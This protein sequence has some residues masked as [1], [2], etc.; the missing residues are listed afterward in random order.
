MNSKYLFLIVFT[1]HFSI[2]LSQQSLI[3]GVV[4][5]ELNKPIPFANVLNLDNSE[6]TSCDENGKFE[7]SIGI[8]QKANIKI[9][10]IG[11]VTS[12]LNL[13]NIVLNKRMNFFLKVDNSIL[14]EQVISS[15]LELIKKKESP[16]QI[17][18]Y[19]T[20]FLNS[21]TSPSLVEATNQISG[22]RPQ[23]N[24]S[25]CNTGDIHINGMEG[26]YSM[27]VID[28]MP[29]MGGLS[30]VYGL[31]GIPT[32]LI[33]QLEVIK[34]PASTLY[35]S[36]AMAGLI[37]VVTKSI[38]CLPKISYDFNISNWGEIQ[39]SI[40]F[41][42]I[43]NDR[44]KAFTT[45]DAFNYN[46]PIDNNEDNFTDLSIKNRVSVFNKFQFL[47]KN[48][49]AHPFNLSFR[50]LNED[51]WGGEMNWD[52]DF[53]GSDSI[54][55]E[56]IVTERFEVYS[57]YQLPIK[58][59]VNW[60]TSFSLHNQK[61]WYGDV[62]YNAKQFIGFNQLTWHKEIKQKHQLL[63]GFAIRYNYYDDNTEATQLSVNNNIVNNQP[64]EWFLPGIF[65]QDNFAINSKHRLLIGWR[66]D[67]HTNHGFIN[68]PRLNYQF[69]FSE[70]S[71]FRIG[72]GN[73][74]RVVNV[75]TEDHAALTG[76]R[77]VVFLEELK[78]EL[79]NNININWTN[80]W[81]ND[82]VKITLESS[83]FQ[84]RFSN[85]IIPDFLTDDNKIIYKNLDGYA[86]SKGISSEVL[87][88]IKSLPISIN[89][90]ATFLDIANYTL[91][92]QDIWIKSNQLL[93]EKYSIK[94]GVNYLL[95]SI[96]IDINYS[97]THYGPIRL[98]ILENDFRPEYSNPYSIHNFKITKK[99]NNGCKLFTGLRNAF[100]FTPPSNSIMRPFDPFDQQTDIN[101][102]NNYTFDASYM[103]A[104]FQGINIIFGGSI[105][106]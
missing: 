103:Y 33:Q 84:S 5:D 28:G 13:Q 68:S 82:M 83:V 18:V 78:P 71:T 77:E 49:N 46:K 93:A 56:S 88:N 27:I 22:L 105:L 39:N 89:A 15:T 52:A 4:K 24:C 23:L 11:F 55:G 102:P 97:G 7:L 31:Q 75:F 25:V 79:S 2:F 87:I 44:I 14:E 54:Y 40:S 64:N 85:K 42:I 51:R 8:T 95:E 45:I 35:G 70:S 36:E 99:F 104:S 101:N 21:V 9:S 38:D 72:Y 17:A 57:A 100:N 67:Y 43:N 47:P 66:T 74:F 29:I 92:D 41:K 19:S 6:G 1:F 61:S 16:I 86:D 60:Q 50:Y 91:D 62:N 80:F 53:R 65:L 73:G 26:S 81:E 20:Q 58:Q 106:F 30:T 59:K 3:L 10:A 98:P 94:W 34:G 37:N 76:S 63:S 90:N 69:D 96:G 48:N 32:N 12:N